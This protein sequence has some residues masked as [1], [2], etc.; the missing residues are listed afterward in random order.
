MVAPSCGVYPQIPQIDTGL[1]T[2][3][4]EIDSSPSLLVFNP[5]SSV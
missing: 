3:A 4:I 5:R 1:K 2:Q